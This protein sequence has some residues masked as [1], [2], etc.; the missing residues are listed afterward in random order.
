MLGIVPILL[1]SAGAIIVAW[2]MVT[3]LRTRIDLSSAIR[4]NPQDLA[5]LRT[6]LN[7]QNIDAAA[8]VVRKHLQNLSQAERTEAEAALTQ[9]SAT[10]RASY[11]RGVAGQADQ[12]PNDG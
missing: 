7:A 5:E 8:A 1:A 10:G 4:A 9:P 2:K 3:K 12:V 11:I 6:Q